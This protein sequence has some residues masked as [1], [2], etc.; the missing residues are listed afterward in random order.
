MSIIDTLPL[1]PPAPLATFNL[2]EKLDSAFA[3][4]L[5]GRDPETD[6]PLPGVADHRGVSTTD[7]VRIKGVVERAR[8]V[9]TRVLEGAEGEEPMDVDEGAEGGD[10]TVGKRTAMERERGEQGMVSFEG[11][12]DNEDDDWE[13]RHV[14]GIFE[15]TLGEL[16]DVLGG[17][18]IGIVTDE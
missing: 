18:P 7:K 12:E 15:K 2:L 16:G 13:E 11:F 4:L 5:T 8:I 3:A 6:E 9:V 1:Y 14:A 10:D 17:E